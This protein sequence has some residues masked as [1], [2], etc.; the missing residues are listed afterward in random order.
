MASV[1]H[2]DCAI[3]SCL[4][5]FKYPGNQVYVNQYAHMLN[6]VSTNVSSVIL[7]K[8]CP[9]SSPNSRENEGKS[10]FSRCC[11][12][13][14]DSG[15]YRRTRITMAAGIADTMNVM[16]QPYFGAKK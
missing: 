14:S 5:S 3:V 4:T 7:R 1:H 15:M 9:N 8:S 13:T 10:F 16:R 11:S 12:Q 6:A 2:P